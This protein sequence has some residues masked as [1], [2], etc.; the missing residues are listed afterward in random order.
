MP[1]VDPPTSTQRTSRNDVPDPPV[2]QPQI[3]EIDK[4]KQTNLKLT[5]ECR[6]LRVAIREL[7]LMIDIA[8]AEKKLAKTRIGIFEKL[9]VESGIVC[10][11]AQSKARGIWAPLIREIIQKKYTFDKTGSEKDRQ[12]YESAIV[13]WQMTHTRRDDIEIII[14]NQVLG[15]RA[16]KIGEQLEVTVDLLRDI[17]SKH[18]EIITAQESKLKTQASA[19][20]SLQ[21]SEK[22]QIISIAEMKIKHE[23]EVKGHIEVI[24]SLKEKEK[25][26]M[27]EMTRKYEA[28]LKEQKAVVANF[29]QKA[30]TSAAA[31]KKTYEKKLTEQSITI[32]NF[33]ENEKSLA[34]QKRI[35]YEQKLEEQKNTITKLEEEKLASAAEMKRL[36]RE[37]AAHREVSVSIL[38]RKREL[39]KPHEIRDDYTIETGNIAAHG[40]TCLADVFRIKSNGDINEQAWFQETYG[41][42]I[43]TA[44][45]YAES[46]AFVKLINMRY[47]LYRC[48]A[49]NRDVDPEFEEGF[50]KLL[51]GSLEKNTK[52]T[53][54]SID[55]FLL[56]SKYGRETFQKL[57]SIWDITRVYQR[58]QFRESR[59]PK[60]KS[61][62]GGSFK[63]V[64]S[65]ASV[66]TGETQKRS[67]LDKIEE[68]G[69]DMLSSAKDAMPWTK[70]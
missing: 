47:E 25:S 13:S 15:D 64:K 43:D 32:T 24:A 9:D 45:R 40:G 30:R 21:E 37:L 8:E 67:K 7:G 33:E 5:T 69:K 55:K 31:V 19:I 59:D 11:E 38:N 10:S 60:K 41:V 36:C 44:D 6:W 29:E 20:S 52:A 61:I 53:P 3:S 65:T 35:E 28:K 23:K 63:S 4:L 14:C 34:A 66:W 18:S 16:A 39:T 48:S 42:S 1:R 68:Y 26:S 49:E 58:K 27:I 62:F 12:E 46:A 57:C 17:Y 51:T 70:H 22:S 56:E 54:E 2:K 50:Q